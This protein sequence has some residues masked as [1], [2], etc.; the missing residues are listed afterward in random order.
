MA[1][2]GREQ[3]VMV[4]DILRHSVRSAH[5]VH[6]RLDHERQRHE[7]EWNRQ[8]AFVVGRAFRR[9]TAISAR[10]SVVFRLAREESDNESQ[11]V[12]PSVQILKSPRRGVGWLLESLVQNRQQHSANSVLKASPRPAGH[13]VDGSRCIGR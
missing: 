10:I 8:H 2:L 5:D 1:V 3:P 9:G 4:H 11:A 13:H 6:G 7:S 12:S